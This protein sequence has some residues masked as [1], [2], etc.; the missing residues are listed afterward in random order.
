MNELKIKRRI[1]DKELYEGPVAL[2]F[3]RHHIFNPNHEQE[4]LKLSKMNQSSNCIKRIA[5]D[6]AP[7][8]QDIACASQSMA[9]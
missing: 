8:E 4:N 1:R 5:V 3:E 2:S 6:T 7:V 9:R